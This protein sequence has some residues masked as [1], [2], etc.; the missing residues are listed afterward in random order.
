MIRLITVDFCYLGPYHNPQETYTYYALPFCK[1][2]GDHHKKLKY[3]GLGEI[4]EGNELVESGAHMYF[5]KNVPKTKICSQ[6][7]TALQ[8]ETFKR[9]ISQHYW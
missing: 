1:P 9:A 8:A 5:G 6:K 4:L 2:E 3:A 7:L